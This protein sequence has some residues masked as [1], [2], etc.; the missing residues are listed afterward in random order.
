MAGTYQLLAEAL[1]GKL[2]QLILS[3]QT[4]WTFMTDPAKLIAYCAQMN[5]LAS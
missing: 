1:S 4:S 2:A 5:T 3:D